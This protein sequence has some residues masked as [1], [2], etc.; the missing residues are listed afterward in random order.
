[1]KRIRSLD[2]YAKK[3]RLL[4]TAFSSC[5][6]VTGAGHGEGLLVPFKQVVVLSGLVLLAFGARANNLGENFGWQFGT[7]QDRVN[8]TAVLDQIEKKKAGYYDAMS[9]VY[10][11]TTYIQRQ[12]NCSL[13]SSTVGNV[14]TNTTAATNSSPTVANSS[15]TTS[16]SL[17]NSD[18]TSAPGNGT[19]GASAS[20]VASS[21][22]NNL[23]N[24][25]T[26]GGSLTAGVTGSNTNSASGAVTAGSGTSDQVL[27]SQQSN[28][29][30]LSAS[31]AGSSAC[32][33]V[34]N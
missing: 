29:G 8:K 21:L 16:T 3:G 9:P 28:A 24:T 2:E 18:T 32:S 7:T 25:Q 15:A 17:A 23:A 30:N 13:S 27:N 11:S 34:L 6:V 19:N 12:Y 1:M 14:G 10:N 5:C 4:N 31:V 22:S 20:G 26:N 33:G